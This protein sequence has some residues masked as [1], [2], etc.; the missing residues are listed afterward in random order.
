MCLKI[1][2]NSDAYGMLEIFKQE[3]DALLSINLPLIVTA[4]DSFRLNN[5]KGRL[6]YT[7]EL[8]EKGDLRD[9]LTER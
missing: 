9:L 3:V 6:C 7:M 2:E 1:I 5:G 4:I 8:C